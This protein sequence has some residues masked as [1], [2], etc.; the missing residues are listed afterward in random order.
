MQTQQ[1]KISAKELAGQWMPRCVLS[2]A[3]LLPAILVTAIGAPLS[4]M[5]RLEM[6]AQDEH[7]QYQVVLAGL[8]VDSARSQV[9]ESQSSETEENNNRTPRVLKP[10][11][12]IW[13][14]ASR[15]E[16]SVAD[17]PLTFESL[18]AS[19]ADIVYHPEFVQQLYRSHSPPIPLARGPP[20]SV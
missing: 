3:L 6:A 20:A 13:E 19:G 4:Q 5:L 9:A 18:V 2:A 8:D 17:I 15:V 14:S 10:V 12:D 7:A 11:S 1:Q 16:L